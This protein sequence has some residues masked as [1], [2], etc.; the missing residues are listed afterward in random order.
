VRSRATKPLPS[1]LYGRKSVTH[2]PSASAIRSL[3]SSSSASPAGEK[4]SMRLGVQSS[5]VNA[6]SPNAAR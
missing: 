2:G 5:R 6:A 3:A 1:S 4:P